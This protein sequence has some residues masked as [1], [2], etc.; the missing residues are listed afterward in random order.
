MAV[1]RQELTS[2]RPSL[3]LLYLGALVM[4]T[5]LLGTALVALCLGSPSAF[6]ATAET[7]AFV[8]NIRLNG[9]FLARASDLASD[10]SENTDL[11]AF[12]DKEAKAEE[13]VIA[14]VDA[15]TAPAIATRDVPV[16][17]AS[18]EVVTGRSAAVD[19]PSAAQ[20]FSAPVGTG[21]LMLAAMITLDR[22]SA[23]KGQAFDTL[24]KATQIN[25]LRQLAGLYNAYG[26]TGDDAALKQ[27]A[28]SELVSTNDRIA[29]LGR[30]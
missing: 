1:T 2:L 7:E 25:A 12:A 24:Y 8:A 28:Q 13:S 26:M 5:L 19:R 4:R 22:L 9:Y 15:R 16:T 21:A 23:S 29:E 6:A 30:L 10:R 18:N 3:R 11:R 14:D 17:V 27:L 20:G